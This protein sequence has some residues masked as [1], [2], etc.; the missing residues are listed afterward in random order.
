M[1]GKEANCRAR[2]GLRTSRTSL[3]WRRRELNH[4]G[5]PT[6]VPAVGTPSCVHSS[7]VHK[8][9]V[10]VSTLRSIPDFGRFMARAALLLSADAALANT[11]LPPV[12]HA[13]KRVHR[14]TGFSV[15][16]THVFYGF[17]TGLGNEFGRVKPP[18]TCRVLCQAAVVAYSLLPHP[19]NRIRL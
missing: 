14:R 17:P 10:V 7:C 12:A 4:L 11:S 5:I 3:V 2:F 18:K 8:G 13:P 9:F 6:P 1:S 16:K 19:A 15:K